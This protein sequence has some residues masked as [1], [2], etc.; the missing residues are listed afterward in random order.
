MRLK[1]RNSRKIVS[2]NKLLGAGGEGEVYATNIDGMVAKVYH[3]GKTPSQKMIDKLLYMLDNTPDQPPSSNNHIAITWPRD[4]L[5]ENGAVRGFL[6]DASRGTAINDA[7]LPGNR[8]KKLPGLTWRHS[9]VMAYNLSWVMANIHAKGYVIGDVNPQN[10]R[11][12][13]DGMVSIIDIDS[14]QISDPART[15]VYPCTVTTP[16]YAAPELT[17]E[18]MHNGK[19]QA[20]QDCFSLAV[21]IYRLL[22]CGNHPFSGVYRRS[23]EPPELSASIKQGFTI[24]DPFGPYALPPASPPLQLIPPSLIPLFERCFV[25]GHA[26]PASRPSA[27]EW[28]AALSPLAGSQDSTVDC[29]GNRLHVYP[30][31]LNDCPWCDL[32]NRKHVDY[33][34]PGHQASQMTR[35]RPRVYAPTSAPSTVIALHPGQMSTP[36]RPI[37]TQAA[38]RRPSVPLPLASS[39]SPLAPP[40]SPQAA[41]TPLPPV[42]SQ[43]ASS[44]PS[45]P[46]PSQSV[47][48]SNMPR[49]VGDIFRIAITLIIAISC[50]LLNFFPVRSFIVERLASPSVASTSHFANQNNGR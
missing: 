28:I 9:L 32:W 40:S 38:Y 10:I 34:D 33:Y 42:Q 17:R 47:R 35:N 22:M 23:G 45:P 37:P 3:P 36:P 5:E 11:V 48:P 6:M 39:V 2:C 25:A 19:R 8:K 1:C 4:L 44:P 24:F 46:T 18:I 7:I 26:N 14:F 31:Y 50:V 16:E 12:L 49:S 15:I 29:P 43:S 21:I 13:P 20:N 30:R 41:F 27:Q